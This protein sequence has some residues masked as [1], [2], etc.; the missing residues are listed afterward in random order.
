MNPFQIVSTLRTQLQINIEACLTLARETSADNF[1]TWNNYLTSQSIEPLSSEDRA[2][3]YQL[4]KSVKQGA[5]P[6]EVRAVLEHH[7]RQMLLVLNNF[8]K[9]YGHES[10]WESRVEKPVKQ[11]GIDLN[12]QSMEEYIGGIQNRNTPSQVLENAA[13]VSY[14]FR[15]YFHKSKA[16]SHL[17][18]T[19]RA[20]R[21]AHADLNVCYF[22][23]TP[24]F[25]SNT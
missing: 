4:N 2:I 8:K 23:G 3:R 17:C 15:E 18:P 25:E 24:L 20:A 13:Q 16:K 14:G 11:L 10:W 22:C 21:P 5:L 1:Q 19:C 12:N 9:E 6:I 7:V